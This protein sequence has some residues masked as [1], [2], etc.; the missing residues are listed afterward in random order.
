MF[1]NSRGL[2]ASP[3]EYVRHQRK[4]DRQ[5]PQGTSRSTDHGSA[6]IS[7]SA[8]NSSVHSLH[9]SLAMKYLST[10]SSHGSVLYTHTLCVVRDQRRT[11]VDLMTAAD[12]DVYLIT[13]P[14]DGPLMH[15]VQNAINDA[16]NRR[17]ACYISTRA[18]DKCDLA[19]KTSR[20]VTPE[21]S[22]CRA[23]FPGRFRPSSLCF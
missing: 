9:A 22:S 11:R 20:V 2:T 8:C 23:P 16:Q 18:S 15:T 21:P 12:V 3:I 14:A 6:A 19:M 17:A 5:V 1:C 7:S 13:E 10:A 4:A